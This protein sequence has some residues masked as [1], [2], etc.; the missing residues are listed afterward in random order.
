MLKRLGIRQRL[1]GF[2][3]R[4]MQGRTMRR[5]SSHYTRLQFVATAK[6]Q[7]SPLIM[8]GFALSCVPIL[9][10]DQSLEGPGADLEA[11]QLAYLPYLPAA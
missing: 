6:K 4:I 3:G 2:A 9:A 11:L 5:R 1:S 7:T 8:N 10:L